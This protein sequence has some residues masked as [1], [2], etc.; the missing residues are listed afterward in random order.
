MGIQRE[1]NKHYKGY[2]VIRVSDPSQVG[3][4]GPETQM[5]DSIAGVAHFPK[6][7]LEI[8][9]EFRLQES[10]SGWNRVK[11][12]RIIDECLDD[13]RK[14][15]AEVVIFPRVDRETRFLAGSFPKLL[16][17][18]KSGMLVYFAHEKL[19][20]DP[21]DHD[22]F[23]QY[24]RLTL[25]AQ[26]YVRVM[27]RNTMEGKKR[28]A[29]RGEIPAGFGKYGG[30]LGLAYDKTKKMLVH[31]PG[32]DTARE[33]LQRGLEKESIRQIT[34]DLQHRN[35]KGAGGAVIG[36]SS[37]G[38]V[39]KNSHVYAGVIRWNGTEIRDRVKDPI[40]K[41]EESTRIAE[42]MR[43]NKQRSYGFGKRKWFSGRVFCQQCGRRYTLDSHKGCYCN[44][45]DPRTSVRCKAPK[46]GLQEL[47]HLAYG[48]MIYA[49]S[50][51]E[52]VIENAST[53]H[54]EWENEFA[55]LKEL[56]AERSLQH[57]QRERR[58]KQLSFQHE[59]G[60]ISDTEYR[61]RLEHI[62]QEA[63]EN[64]TTKFDDFIK[65]KPPTAEEVAEAYDRVLAY[66]P[67]RLHW[68]MMNNDTKDEYAA[69]MAEELDLKII[70]GPPMIKRHKYSVQVKMNIPVLL[71]DLPFPYE[72][73]NW[74]NVTYSS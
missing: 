71:D 72:E 6:G 17:V 38:R 12:G 22:T 57:Q 74:A 65:N 37:V 66:K 53:K 60:G 27:R 52:A 28:A 29:E 2:V 31:G 42:I 63:E 4:Y 40:I 44:G 69:K 43:A 21:D 1:L 47:H 9:R 14:G 26:G 20:L 41:E 58:Q 61:E 8:V 19:L 50:S 62:Q 5:N 30:Y 64:S 48:A 16:E 59:M 35:V 39:L 34:I 33:I 15:I 56:D 13:Y 24:Q 7:H 3:R 70:I 10:A 36:H 51:P 32:L 68:E 25:D 45:S 11:W 54:V 55:R 67:L 46:I 18:I 73:H 49:L 23:E